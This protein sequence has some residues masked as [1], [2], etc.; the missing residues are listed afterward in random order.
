MVLQDYEIAVFAPSNILY[1]AFSTTI[2]LVL[3]SN[4][5]A[6]VHVHRLIN[7]ASRIA[8][9]VSSDVTEM[10]R[11]LGTTNAIDYYGSGRKVR[12]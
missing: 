2:L 8:L 4:V 12:G 7:R 10:G 9:S 1:R 5:G 3:K 11:L 6:I